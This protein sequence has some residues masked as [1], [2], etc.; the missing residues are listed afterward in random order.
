MLE[1]HGGSRMFQM[2]TAPGL[3]LL[4]LGVVV[5]LGVSFVWILW[6]IEQLSK[7]HRN[8]DRFG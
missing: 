6:E 8:S 5:G 4:F 3:T 2:L 7:S 1:A